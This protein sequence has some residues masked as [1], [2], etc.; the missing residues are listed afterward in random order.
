MLQVSMS[1]R[2]S[3]PPTLLQRVSHAIDLLGCENVRVCSSGPHVLLGVLEGEPYA[4]L[5]PLGD[6]SYGLAFRAIGAQTTHNSAW[7]PLLLVDDLMSVI[8]HALVAVDV[9][10]ETPQ[11]SERAG[12]PM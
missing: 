8:Q 10:G 6:A 3:T 4:R 11:S 9:V 12:F 1:S 2:T 7:E 5:T